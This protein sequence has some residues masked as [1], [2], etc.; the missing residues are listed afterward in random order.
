MW[1]LSTLLSVQSADA[2]TYERILNLTELT[3]QST[4]VATGTVHN[5]HSYSRDNLIWTEVTLKVDESLIG[6][7]NQTLTFEVLG[8]AVDGLHLNIPGS[9]QFK[10]GQSI[11]VFLEGQELVGF[12]QGAFSLEN[13]V[14]S[15]GLG[16]LLPEGPEDF[17]VKSRLPNLESSY[18]CLAPK[19]WDNYSDDWNLRSVL[20]SVAHPGEYAVESA[21][22]LEGFEYR[23]ELCGDEQL[24]GV[25][26]YLLD[27]HDQVVM[28]DGKTGREG[29][30]TYSPD[31]TG[32]YRLVVSPTGVPEAAVGSSISIGIAYR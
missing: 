27:E 18:E 26:L 6:T 20:H 3:K 12:G 5:Q 22:L 13:G 31:T 30:L 8:G 25:Q 23:F 16:P 15:R 7:R 28:Q 2:I 29:A 17:S 32:E 24:G 10:D 4:H 11:L 14:A 19:L 21:V 9:P 1:L